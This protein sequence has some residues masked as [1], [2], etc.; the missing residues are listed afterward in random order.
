[1]SK[2]RDVIIIP[3]AYPLE[4]ETWVV[5]E[6]DATHSARALELLYLTNGNTRNVITML[7]LEFKLDGVVLV[8]AMQLASHMY[9]GTA[10]LI[11]SAWRKA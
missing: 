4:E 3:K 9:Y 1:M 6:M 11:W 8:G 2:V 10:T 7:Q 5:D